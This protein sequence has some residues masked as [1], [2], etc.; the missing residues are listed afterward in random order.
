MHRN[1][2]RESKKKISERQ[3]KKI[4]RIIRNRYPDFGPTFAREKLVEVHKI[5]VGKESLRKIMIREGI[6]KLRPRKTNHEYRMWRE[7]KDYVGEL[8]QFDGSYHE[9]LMMPVEK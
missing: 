6:W 4:A 1:R 9:P 7:R 8:I 3:I 2:G 5:K